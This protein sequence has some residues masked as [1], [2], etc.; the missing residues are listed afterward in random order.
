MDGDSDPVPQ[1]KLFIKPAAEPAG[2]A[3]TPAEKAAAEGDEG[4]TVAP[5]PEA[6]TA[7]APEAEPLP[8]T[9]SGEPQLASAGSYCILN[10]ISCHRARW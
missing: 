6:E 10:R 1:Q 5:A 2:E 9:A 7:A 8:Q 4:P 3:A